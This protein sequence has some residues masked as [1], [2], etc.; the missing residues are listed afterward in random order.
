M[1]PKSFSSLSLSKI[2]SGASKSIN[3]IKEV[4]PI[5]QKVLPVASN[6]KNILIK[7]LNKNDTKLSSKEKT[8]TK[9]SN[10]YNSPTFFK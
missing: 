1:F 10:S 4:M 2:I 3:I 9:N 8:I 5:Y 6:V 7:N